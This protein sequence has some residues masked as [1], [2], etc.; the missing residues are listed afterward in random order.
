MMAKDFIEQFSFPGQLYVDQ[1]RTVYN[2]MKCKRGFKYL[3][4]S[5]G[6]KKVKDAL[7]EGYSQGKTQGDGLQMGGSWVLSKSKGILYSHLEEYAGDHPDLQDLL[8]TIS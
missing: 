5:N 8:K 7:A 2:A 4:T 6:I 3:L 1:Q